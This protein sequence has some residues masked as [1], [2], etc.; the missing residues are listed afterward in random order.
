VDKAATGPSFHNERV[1]STMT[2]T[3]HPYFPCMPSTD[4]LATTILSL[5]PLVSSILFYFQ[6]TTYGKLDGGVLA[7]NSMT[8]RHWLGPMLSSKWS[9]MIFESP[10]WIWVAILMYRDVNVDFVPV[11]LANLIL[12]TWFFVH[13]IHRSVLYPFQVSSKSKVPLGISACAFCYTFCNGYLQ[14]YDLIYQQQFPEGYADSWQFLCGVVLT[15]VGFAIAYQS[16]HILLALKNANNDTAKGDYQ[17]PHGGLFRYVSSP[18]YLGELI[19]W[20][21]FCIACNFSLASISFVVW[22]AAN[23]V[24]RAWHT[25]HWYRRKFRGE[26]DGL[27]RRAICPCVF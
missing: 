26:Y 23:L 8:S 5:S 4:A 3:P 13:Y 27:N 1:A 22:T 21:G 6:P 14:V 9:W 20:T 24:P 15:V 16:D 25:H 11:P 7:T 19:E 17:I 18:H 10:S 12:V 2:T